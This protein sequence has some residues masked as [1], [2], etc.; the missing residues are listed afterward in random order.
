MAFD[1]S[2]TARVVGGAAGAERSEVFARWAD[3]EPAAMTRR[4]RA[5]ERRSMRTVLEKV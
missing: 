3:D 1:V 4:N 5:A 2:D